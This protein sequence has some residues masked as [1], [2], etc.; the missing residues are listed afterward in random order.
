MIFVTVG[1][2]E[3][4][5]NRLVEEVDRLLKEGTVREEVFI[6]RGIGSGIP[7]HCLSAELISY[8]DMIR[9]VR[10]ARIVITHGGPGSIMLPLSVGKVPIVVPRQAHHGEHVDDHQVAFARRLASLKRIIAV[11]DIETLGDAISR[12][13]PKQYPE[14]ALGAGAHSICQ[15][16]KSLDAYCRTH[17]R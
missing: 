6:Q 1:T 7:E 9:Y 12:Y 4:P 10:E 3:Q 11:F 13:D 14:N 17:V 5:F 8:G 2:H 15:L 16:V